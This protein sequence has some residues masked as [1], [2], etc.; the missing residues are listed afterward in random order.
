[1]N[2]IFASPSHISG[3]FHT[4]EGV[5]ISSL[6]NNLMHFFFIYNLACTKNLN[7]FL[8]I[9]THLENLLDI[10][11]LIKPLPSDAVCVFKEEFGGT[12]DEYFL[13][14]LKNIHKSNR[15]LK[16]QNLP[17]PLNFW[18]EGWYCANSLM[19]SQ[20]NINKLNFQKNIIEEYEANFKFLEKE[21][22]ISLHYRGTDFKTHP[23][24]WGDMR[25]PFRYYKQCLNEAKAKGI[26]VINVFSDKKDEII[27]N[28]KEFKN[29]FEFYFISNTCYM[30]WYCLFKSKNLISSNSTFCWSA[31][32]YNKDIVFQPK[33]FLLYNVDRNVLFPT[34]VYY[35]KSIVI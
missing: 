30:D 10:T 5:K 4:Y 2:N 20:E 27:E 22:H 8:P 29:D 26:K 19:P 13:K 32:L 9:S 17:L 11:H 25:L 6:G 12:I 15:L 14:D 3:P 18:V 31:G 28:L 34:D 21:N 23:I 1:M 33:K 7:L 24:G 35:N 16:E